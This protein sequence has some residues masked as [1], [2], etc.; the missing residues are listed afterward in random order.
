MGRRL[1]ACSRDFYDNRVLKQ[2]SLTKW[3]PRFD[4]DA[5][6]DRRRARA[7]IAMIGVD[8]DLVDR[9][10]DAS[11]G[12]DPVQVRRLEVRDANGTQRNE[13]DVVPPDWREDRTVLVE[14]IPGAIGSSRVKGA[15]S[16]GVSLLLT[17]VFA[18]IG[19]VVIWVFRLNN[20]KTA[21]TL[22][23]LPAF[24]STNVAD[25]SAHV[26]IRGSEDTFSA[27]TRGTAT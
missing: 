13:Q 15:K 11:F 21:V 4:G 16:P 22:E 23:P 14:Y 25:N 27:R 17:G 20:A 1:T 2:R 26:R 19:G 3:A 10:H 8:L 12:D 6:C 18:V 9:W 7:I 24:A 5:V